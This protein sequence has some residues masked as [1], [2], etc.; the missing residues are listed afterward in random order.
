MPN[1]ISLNITIG[2]RNFKVKIDEKDQISV[3]K[4][5]DQINAKIAELKANYGGKDMQDFLSMALL[6][7]L[8]PDANLSKEK[9]DIDR[10]LDQLNIL[11]DA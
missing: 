11:L 8:T 2:D 3:Q 4:V 9:E 5:C 6:S 7:F 1:F 10:A